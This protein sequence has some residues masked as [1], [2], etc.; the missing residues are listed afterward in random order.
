MIVMW[1]DVGAKGALVIKD[2][3]SNQYLLRCT[4]EFLSFKYSHNRIRSLIL[5]YC[6]GL[7][8]I[9]EA[10][11]SKHT[12][13]KHSKFYW[14]IELIW[15]E[16]NTPV[17]YCMDNSARRIVLSWSNYESQTEMT[18]KG[19]PRVLTWKE[20]KQWVMNHFN[21]PRSDVADAMLFIEW[22]IQSINK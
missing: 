14:I 10:M 22:Y 9:W 7:M 16:T 4:H 5:Q 18:K 13:K 8:V 20:A 17:V 2:T 3:E 12:V 11:G 1:I 19:T 6:I 15:E 21:E